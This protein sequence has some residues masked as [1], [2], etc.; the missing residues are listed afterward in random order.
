VRLAGDAPSTAR[1]LLD[2]SV[3]ILRRA[4]PA[5]HPLVLSATRDLERASTM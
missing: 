3:A 4:L 1:P 2:H 5:S